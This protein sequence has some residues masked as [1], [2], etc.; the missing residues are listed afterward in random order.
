MVYD[1]HQRGLVASLMDIQ[2]DYHH[3]IISS[4]HVHLDHH[5]CLEIIVAK[6]TAEVLEE[7]HGRLK[8][9]KGVFHVGLAIAS[10]MDDEGEHHH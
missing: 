10:A 5:N 2:H 8:A 6:G 9:Q 4:Q 7:L 1:H 3:A